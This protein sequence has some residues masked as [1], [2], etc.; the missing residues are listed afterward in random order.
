MLIGL[1]ADNPQLHDVYRLDI[2]TGEMEKIEDN[3]ASPAGL[4]T[5]TCRYAAEPSW[6]PTAASRC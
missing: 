3:P 1:N 4:S 6:M 5:V 2:S